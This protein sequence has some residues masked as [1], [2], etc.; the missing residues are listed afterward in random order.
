MTAQRHAAEHAEQPRRLADLVGTY[1]VTG[2][3]G[4]AGAWFDTTAFAQPTGVRFGNTGRNQFYG[5][6]G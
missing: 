3:I 2:K 4:A 6:G 5:P 1:N